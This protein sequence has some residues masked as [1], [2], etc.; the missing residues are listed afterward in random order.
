MVKIS[1]LNHMEECII[2]LLPLT[3][4]HTHVVPPLTLGGPPPVL[5]IHLV[6]QSSTG[7]PST[8]V[9]NPNSSGS[10]ST[11]YTPY[12]SCPKNNPYFPFPS[13][14]QPVSPPPGQPHVDVNFFHPSPIQ[15][16]HYFE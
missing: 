12:G 13:P 1:I 4:N 6:S 14:P 10:T 8:P 11:S 7:P 3:K 2:T 5:L 16:F 9:Y 15:Q